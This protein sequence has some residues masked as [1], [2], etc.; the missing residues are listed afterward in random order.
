MNSLAISTVETSRGDRLDR[1]ADAGLVDAGRVFALSLKPIRDVMG[2]RW[3]QRA[4]Q[5]WETVERA[6][7]RRMPAPDVFLRLDDV[8]VLAAIASTDAYEGQV[9]CAEVMRTVLSFFLGRSVEDDLRIERV[10]SLDGGIIVTEAIDLGALPPP[11]RPGPVKRPPTTPP[12]RWTPPLAGRRWNTAFLSEREGAIDLTFEIAPVWRLDVGVISA[13]AIRTRVGRRSLQPSDADQEAMAH[14]LLDHLIPLMDEYRREGGQFA[15]IAP[16]HFVNAASTRPRLGLIGRCAGVM[17]VMRKA[18]VLEL[19]GVTPAA[20]AA[21]VQEAA[22]MLRPFV[23][24]LTVGVA[25]PADVR[26]VGEA[27]APQGLSIDAQKLA[28]EPLEG[29]IRAARRRS[30]NIVVHG[31]RRGIDE[32]G[33]NALGASHV[34]YS[35]DLSPLPYPVD[36]PA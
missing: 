4:E 13:Y 19:E 34:S 1:V 16:L 28:R 27:F 15:L 7:V 17:E 10:A 23:N 9:R 8:T 20:P 6:L 3:P 12:H 5:V 25:S 18:V 33:L 31:V 30:P 2:A 14:A 24:T 11:P 36:R 22:A 26:A 35:D 32:D 29:V 21:L